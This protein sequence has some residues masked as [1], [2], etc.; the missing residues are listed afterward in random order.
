M[1]ISCHIRKNKLTAFS[2][3][4]NEVYS[5]R[6]IL[7]TNR[8]EYLRGR[9]NRINYPRTKF[10]ELRWTCWP[11]KKEEE[12]SKRDCSLGD[13]TQFRF[14]KYATKLPSILMGRS[15]FIFTNNKISPCLH[16]RLIDRTW[17]F[18]SF[19]SQFCLWTIKNE[20]LENSTII[21]HKL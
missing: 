4:R 15:D 6:G 21:K 14:R 19:F 13:L 11:E 16:F 12:D 8:L 18:S 3:M 5:R 7:W 20:C 1:Q 10:L 2:L 9:Q 17:F